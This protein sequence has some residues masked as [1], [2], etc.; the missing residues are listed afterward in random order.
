MY[1]NLAKYRIIV[2]YILG[3]T[4]CKKLYRSVV[5]PCY[6]VLQKYLKLH[7][8]LQK[9]PSINSNPDLNTNLKNEKE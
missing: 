8:R 3:G 1:G 7:Y 6:P 2:Q 5:T 4:D 9:N